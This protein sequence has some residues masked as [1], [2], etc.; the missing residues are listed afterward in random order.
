MDLDWTIGALPL[1]EDARRRVAD[2]WARA[3]ARWGALPFDRLLTRDR[4]AVLARTESGPLG[5]REVAWNGEGPCP[6][7]PA[8]PLPEPAFRAALDRVRALG[9]ETPPG[10]ARFAGPGFGQVRLEAEILRPLR[11]A[12]ARGQVTVSGGRLE[13]APP[14]RFRR[15]HEAERFARI[16]T[17]GGAE[18]E[19]AVAVAAG[20][21]P[22]ERIVRFRTTGSVDGREVQRARLDSAGE[23]LGI[24]VLRDEL[25]IARLA[26]LSRDEVLRAPPAAGPEAATGADLAAV[27]RRLDCPAAAAPALPPDP[28]A[29]ARDALARL[30]VPPAPAAAPPAP[31]ERV[32]PGTAASPG[33][34]TGPLRIA[35]RGRSPRDYEGFILA[36]PAL[37]PADNAAIHRAEGVLSTGGAVLSHAGMIAR[38][39]GKPALLLEGRWRE[40]DGP[41]AGPPALVLATEDYREEEREVAGHPVRIRHDVVERDLELRDGDLVV[42]D[43]DEAVL[44]VLGG[45]P[46]A[47]ALHEC[48]RAFA[49]ADVRLARARGGP[50]VLALR[51]DRLRARRRLEQQLARVRDPGVARHAVREILLGDAVSAGPAGCE[52][53]AR[54]LSP[55]LA[56]PAVGAA[57][58][59][60]VRDA[61]RRLARRFESA[62]DRAAER[63]PTAAECEVLALR[64]RARETG[65]ALESARETLR[66]CGVPPGVDAPAADRLDAPALGRLRE[67][68]AG[69]ASDVMRA[70]SHRG[71]ARLRHLL[72]RVDRVDAAL[73]TPPEERARLAGP[74]LALD[75]ADHASRRRAEGRR[76]VPPGE[77]GLELAA[78][79]GWKAANLAEIARLVGEDAVPAWFAVTDAAFREVMDGPAADRPGAGESLGAAIDR[80]LRDRGGT[81][82]VRSA[83]VRALWEAVRLPAALVREVA[84][85]YDGLGG[86]DVPVAVR[87]STREEDSETAARAGEFDTF[88]FVRGRLALLHHLKR[89]WAGFWTERAIHNRGVLGAAA[90]GGGVIVQRMIPARVAGVAQTAN[91]ATGDLREIIVNAG[92][93]LGEGIVS[94]RVAADRIAV[95]KEGDP[96]REP[97]RFRCVTADKTEQVVPNR[98]AGIGTVRVPTLS[99]QRLRPALDSVELAELVR[100]ALFLEGAYGYPLDLEFALEGTRLWILQ[101]RPV[102]ALDRLLRDSLDRY[103]LAAAPAPREEAA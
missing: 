29:A 80:V 2:A 34:A 62:R 26:E 18:S 44:R 49:R 67:L 15:E 68:R 7:G 95:A 102:A 57:A 77:A 74:R 9:V 50:D 51:G 13:A 5:E 39:S 73:G 52:E 55:L 54:L 91:T 59:E 21:A 100:T 14:S 16:L 86:G 64:A 28:S 93:G 23:T 30:R 101:A 89:A 81:D 96:S 10:S 98:L 63:I 46:E 92:F 33:R 47:L 60:C 4:R 72:R 61:V 40:G 71:D 88:L 41:A 84:E 35:A 70:A 56:A 32:V 37:T 27:L 97:L 82:A 22:L 66:R 69:L 99:H 53:R 43:A 20:L 90:V 42:L 3:F 87:S 103:P 11:R 19:R 25:G 1:D 12:I 78:E 83:R 17:A 36:A 38:E 94:G 65:S 31:G 76:V 79:V 85:A 75:V 24:F 48:L 58:R 8:A 6:D 45:D